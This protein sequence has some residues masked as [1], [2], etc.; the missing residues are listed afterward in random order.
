VPPLVPSTRGRPPNTRADARPTS[1]YAWLPPPP[2]A[3]QSKPTSTRPPWEEARGPL[4]ID[5]DPTTTRIHSAR[6]RNPWCV[7]F[8]LRAALNRLQ[9]LE[10]DPI[11]HRDPL[12]RAIHGRARPSRPRC[13]PRKAGVA[14]SS[15]ARS[16]AGSPP[17]RDPRP[18]K[19]ILP[20]LL[21]ME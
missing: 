7:G 13:S 11:P 5:P 8:L 2:T 21:S 12:L 9:I 17:R 6:C 19:P 18:G 4:R 16:T 15:S 20:T 3:P 10:G 14:V 1:F